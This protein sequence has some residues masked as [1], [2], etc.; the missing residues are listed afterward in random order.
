ML[1]AGATPGECGFRQAVQ[2][3]Y[4]G[5]LRVDF[6]TR[7]CFVGVLVLGDEVLI[8]AVPME[9]DMDPVVNPA[10]QRLEADPRSPPL[11]PARV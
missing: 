3:P 8:G 6:Q 11:P 5:P 9:E 2:V 10:L 7:C 4:V 1:N